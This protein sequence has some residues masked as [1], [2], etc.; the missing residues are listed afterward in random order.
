MLE[1][2]TNF[3]RINITETSSSTMTTETTSTMITNTDDA[4]AIEVDNVINV[5]EE[6][7]EIIGD[8]ENMN[9]ANEDT[10]G[11][12][13]WWINGIKNI[14]CS[15]MDDEDFVYCKLT[16][17]NSIFE[18]LTSSGMTSYLDY[19][20]AF[21]CNNEE[22]FLTNNL[23]FTTAKLFDDIFARRLIDFNE[24]EKLID[25]TRTQINDIFNEDTYIHDNFS[26]Y[27]QDLFTGLHMLMD[28]L[29]YYSTNFKSNNY[30][31]MISLLNN[32]CV[33]IIY[34]KFYFESSSVLDKY[35][36]IVIR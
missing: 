29:K 1:I 10:F 30:H 23:I 27:T 36:K 14:N 33:I 32:Y 18:E 6:V 15:T 2:S 19:F 11:K 3:N 21:C 31:N 9:I 7:N 28:M 17:P 24:V 5:D 13:E 8:I 16:L 12:V 25:E 20:D 34:L 22:I 35:D 4:M 26:T